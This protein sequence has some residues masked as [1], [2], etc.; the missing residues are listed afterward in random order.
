MAGPGSELF[1]DTAKQEYNTYLDVPMDQLVEDPLNSGVKQHN[2]AADHLSDKELNFRALREE[3]SKLKQESEYWRGQAEAYSRTQANQPQQTTQQDA[4]SALDWDDSRDVRKA[5]E[6]LKEQNESL[7]YE[8]KDAITAINTKSN[9]SDWNTLVTQHVPELTSKNPIF[10]EMI[11]KASNPYE[12][13]YLLA[14]LNAKA[15]TPPQS[16]NGQR[17]IQNSQKPQSLSSVAGNGSLS[18]ADYYA[19]MSD[20]D[21]MKIAGRNMANI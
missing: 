14:E 8:L 19:S 3:T 15:S 9:R 2:D 5:F 16:N 10:A 7:R 18:S 12:A 20:E 1:P 4:Y 17:A 21:F 13:A 6:S 11:Q